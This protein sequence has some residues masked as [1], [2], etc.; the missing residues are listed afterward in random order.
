[1]GNRL[2]TRRRWRRVAPRRKRKTRQKEVNTK[3][4]GK[5]KGVHPKRERERLW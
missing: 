5:K 3:R 1:M 2:S 4:A